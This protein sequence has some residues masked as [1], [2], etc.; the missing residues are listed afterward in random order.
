MAG[1]PADVTL[2]L[3][4]RVCVQ[5]LDARVR[6]E[7]DSVWGQASALGPGIQTGV[8]LGLDPRVCGQA[9]DARVRHEHDSVE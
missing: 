9:P 6:H 1:T 2:G 8:T 3:D 4:P 5:T 7:H